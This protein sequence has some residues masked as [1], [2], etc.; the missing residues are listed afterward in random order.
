MYISMRVYVMTYIY[1]YL[2]LSIYIYIWLLGTCVHARS[3]SPR[4][5]KAILKY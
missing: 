5:A 4:V 2:S 3:Q 1:I